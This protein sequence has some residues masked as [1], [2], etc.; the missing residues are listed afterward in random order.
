MLGE[1]YLW[2]ESRGF[3]SR[4]ASDITEIPSNKVLAPHTASLAAHC[5]TQVN[6]PKKKM[7]L[8]PVV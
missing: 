4:T 5:F 1:L 2:S 3:E 7:T 6:V 8:C